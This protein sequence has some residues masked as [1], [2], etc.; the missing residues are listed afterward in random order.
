[1]QLSL[2]ALALFEVVEVFEEEKPGGLLR[3]IELGSAAGLLAQDI[4][5]V[6]ECLFEHNFD[7][8]A[9]RASLYRRNSEARGAIEGD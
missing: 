9:P 5:D 1:V 6:L 8:R 4:V 2:G 3:L 7:R